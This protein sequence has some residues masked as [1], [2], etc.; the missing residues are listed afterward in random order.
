L[1]SPGVSKII[2]NNLSDIHKSTVLTFAD[3]WVFSGVQIENKDSL[4]QQSLTKCGF[5]NIDR[6]QINKKL[7]Y[8]NIFAHAKKNFRQKDVSS[9]LRAAAFSLVSLYFV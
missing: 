8:S 3:I 9:I 6:Q 2:E 7:K 4:L 5:E 1:A